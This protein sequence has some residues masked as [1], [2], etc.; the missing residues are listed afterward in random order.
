MK[1]PRRAD[2]GAR[3]LAAIACAC[4]AALTACGSSDS[5]GSADDR[6]RTLTAYFAASPDF[7]DPALTYTARG[8]TA[9]WTTYTPLL[10]YRHEAGLA[11]T[12]LI[13]GLAES[14]PRIS[15][16]GKTYRLRLRRGLRYSDGTPARASDFEHAIKRVLN[17][18]SGGSWAYLPIAGAPEYLK[19]RKPD[20]DISGIETDDAGGAITIRLTRSVGSF[21]DAL[22]LPFA[23]LVPS[24]TPFENATSDPPPGIGAFKVASSVPNR[25]LTLVRDRSFRGLPGVPVA[26]LDRVEVKVVTNQH[27]QIEDVIDNKVDWVQSPPPPDQMTLVEQRAKGRFEPFVLNSLA[28]VFLNHRVAPFDDERVRKAVAYAVDRRAVVRLFGGLLR[29]TCNFLPPNMQGYERL[30]PCPY[31]DPDGAPDVERAKALIREAGADGAAVTVWGS[32]DAV[33]APVTQ[34]LADAFNAIGLDATPKLVDASTYRQTVGNEKTRAQAGF[35]Q[36]VSDFPHPSNLMS[37][38]TGNGIQPTNSLNWGNVDNPR[39]NALA[40]RADA[41][42]DL[43]RAAPDYAQIDRLLV[44]DADLVPL[45]NFELAKL[46]SER[47]DFDSFIDH[48]VFS[49]DLSL[50]TFRAP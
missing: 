4:A 42:P 44:E 6:S 40:D 8:W 20:G 14:L 27:R 1:K 9:L 21:A 15:P 19:A 36:V 50:L 13:P 31:G 25:S 2:A 17:L 24:T 18:G 33:A 12:E 34:Y 3:S 39:I 37:L 48:P 11:G 32:N 23:A 38:V 26:K 7:V 5:S 35:G 28:Y 46:V 49:G 29:T 47:V 10:T 41:M 16:D 43:A 45:G 22:A 30:D